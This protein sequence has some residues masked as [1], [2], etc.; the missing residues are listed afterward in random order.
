MSELFGAACILLGPFLIIFGVPI[1]IFNVAEWLD[2][3]FLPGLRE[4]RTQAR[5]ARQESKWQNGR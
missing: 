4:R 1:L 3:H 2:D 5:L